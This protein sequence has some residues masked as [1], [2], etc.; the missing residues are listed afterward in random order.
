VARVFIGIPTVN[1]PQFVVEAINSVHRQT[2][3]D[4]R[5][6]VSD[7]QSAGNA[8]ELVERFVVGLGDPRFTFYRQ[9]VNDGE[10]GQGRYFSAASGNDEFFI[11]LHD[12]DV[13][14]PEYLETAV[15]ALEDHPSASLF[16]ANPYAM[17]RTGVR[18]PQRTS[19]LLGEYGRKRAREGLFDVLWMHLMHV[20]PISGT[21]F[22]KRALV[23]S[24]F[25]DDD[26]RGNYPFENDVFLRLGDIAAKGWLQPR[27]LLGLRFHNDSSHGYVQPPM[28]NPHRFRMTLLR[29]YVRPS[30]DDPR[31]VRTT[32][33]LYVRRRYNGRLERQRKRI[34]SRL[35]RADAL[36]R[37]RQGDLAGCR[38]SLYRALSENRR[39]PKAWG[40]VPFV[41]L[42]PGLLHALLPPIR[43]NAVI[44]SASQSPRWQLRSGSQD[45]GTAS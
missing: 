40:L 6:I 11:I 42:T 2:F 14:S 4:Y 26:G 44:S 29:G 33:N 9:P 3:A 32:L 16:V 35:Y 43:H 24:G 31:I 20:T 37:L 45:S 27:E 23:N 7:N 21:V 25:A 17:D 13:L 30:M 39:S 12:D 34:V 38:T 1:R 22:R 36:I 28:G 18:S 8:A 10:Y 5:V 41:W 19:R 15:R